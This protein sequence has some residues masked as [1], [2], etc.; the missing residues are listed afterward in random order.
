MSILEDPDFKMRW[1]MYQ[2]SL[3][4]GIPIVSKEVCAV[5]CAMLVVHGN[6]EAFTHNHRLVAELLYAMKRFRLKGGESCDASFALM[7]KGYING[8]DLYYEREG[9]VPDYINSLFKERYGFEFNI[10]NGK[11]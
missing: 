5:I 9:G 6:H 11:K 4:S 10:N 7:L 2:S 1:A 3:S 8:L